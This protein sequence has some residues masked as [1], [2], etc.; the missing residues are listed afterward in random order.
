MKSTP[1]SGIN[2]IPNEL[3]GRIISFVLTDPEFVTCVVN[4]TPRPLHQV[5]VLMHVSRRFRKA[6]HGSAF[7]QDDN[8]MGFE[9]LLFTDP[10]L[11]TPNI[12]SRYGRL[13]HALFDDPHFVSCIKSTQKWTFGSLESLLAVLNRIPSFSESVLQLRL[14]LDETAPA[15]RRLSTCSNLT[16][17]VLEC[18]PED[19]LDL[20][21]ISNGLPGLRI[22]FLKY[23]KLVAGSLE[24]CA[25]L[26]ELAFKA[27]DASDPLSPL[28]DLNH[29]DAN[30]QRFIPFASRETLRRI[31]FEDCHSFGSI[32]TLRDF[33]KLEYLDTFDSPIASSLVHRLE[34]SQAKLTYLATQV[35]LSPY[36][37]RAHYPLAGVPGLPFPLNINNHPWPEHEW[38]ILFQPCLSLLRTIHLQL[39]FQTDQRLTPG[40]ENCYIDASMGILGAIASELPHI[41]TVRLSAGLDM[42]RLQTLTQLKNLKRLDLNLPRRYIRGVDALQGDDRAMASIVC[43]TVQKFVENAEVQCWVGDWDIRDGHLHRN[44][45][46]FSRL[47]LDS[48]GSLVLE[49][50]HNGANSQVG[51]GVPDR[52][53]ATRGVASRGSIIVPVPRPPPAPVTGARNPSGP[54]E[55]SEPLSLEFQL[56]VISFFIIIVVDFILN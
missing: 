8:F 51:H 19:F 12:T 45:S 11:T 10:K 40:V 21:L 50:A 18:D 2:A 27:S 38:R 7:W 31:T 35:C 32:W 22:L 48:E 30:G 43:E 17:L 37:N 56:W 52:S 16:K 1:K 24:H 49:P 26:E 13:C 46:V 53:S 42:G 25:K 29:A 4:G 36:R 3:L 39:L 47:A 6:T 23:P 44:L 34:G 33:P 54:P 20:S 28:L 14:H 15:L 41:E 9:T 5:I 55:T